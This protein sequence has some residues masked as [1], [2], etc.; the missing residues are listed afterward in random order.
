M[1]RNFREFKHFVEAQYPQFIGHIH[2]GIHPPPLHAQYIAQIA[3]MSWFGG[4]VLMLG[5]QSIFSALGMPT[6]Q[7]YN[8]M[9]ENKGMTMVGLFV[10]NSIGNS[11]LATGAFEI[12]VDGI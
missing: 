9:Q 5:G 7:F 10:F 2:G 6:P 8:W 12:Y 11:M 1:S 3:S 4:I